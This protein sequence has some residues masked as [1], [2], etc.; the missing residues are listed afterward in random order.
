MKKFD[1][2]FEV[3]QRF[4]YSMTVEA[5]TPKEAI[6][7]SKDKDFD[8]HQAEDDYMLES[9]DNLDTIKVVGE[10]IQD[11][12]NSSHLKRFDEPVRQKNEAL[13]LWEKYKATSGNKCPKCGS[14]DI[15]GHLFN[16]EYMEAWRDVNCLDCNKTWTEFFTMTYMKI[17]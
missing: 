5:N 11:G 1:I 9:E 2:E 15:I 13:E 14:E 12:D 7:F 17:L 16:S 6:T 3:N 10:R 4:I 8:R